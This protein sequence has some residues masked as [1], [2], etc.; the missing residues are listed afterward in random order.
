[1]AAIRVLAFAAAS[2][3]V[4]SI[5][6]DSET[7]IDW[8]MSAKA[9]DSPH[10][11]A[12]YAAKLLADFAPEVVVTEDVYVAKHKGAA[13]RAIITALADAAEREG[14]LTVSLPRE[15]RYPNKYAEAEALVARFPEL[16][17][18]QPPKR[19]FYESEPRNTVLFK[20]LALAL[21]LADNR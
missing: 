15:Q 16:I 6:L 13:T 10:E 4:A 20:A 2:G 12:A 1:M 3:R 8:R 14:V 21:Q 18:W 11:A 19:I 7:L 17:P 5:V 9:A